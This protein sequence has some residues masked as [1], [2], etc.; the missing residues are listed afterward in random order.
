[1]RKATKMARRG[2]MHGGVKVL[3]IIGGTTFVHA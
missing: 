1:M 2:E 3:K